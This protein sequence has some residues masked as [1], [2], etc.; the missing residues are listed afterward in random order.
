MDNWVWLFLWT[1]GANDL[2]IKARLLVGGAIRNDLDRF[3]SLLEVFDKGLAVE[4]QCNWRT[5]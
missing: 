2:V 4:E 3:S 5:I 1:F